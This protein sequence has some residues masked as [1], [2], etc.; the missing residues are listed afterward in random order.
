MNFSCTT[1]WPEARFI[2]WIPDRFSNQYVKNSVAHE[3]WKARKIVN[4][5]LIRAP[6]FCS[7]HS[8][9]FMPYSSCVIRR[10]RQSWFDYRDNGCFR[11]R[12]PRN[13][14]P[15]SSRQQRSHLCGRDPGPSRPQC[16]PHRACRR[17]LPSRAIWDRNRGRGQIG[18]DGRIDRNPQRRVTGIMVSLMDVPIPELFLGAH[19]KRLAPSTSRPVLG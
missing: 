17:F 10:F 15:A 7:F 4:G 5:N 11:I 2:S 16:T 14:S 12:V 6:A 1:A 19:R 8:R 3:G 13:R 9:A 18:I